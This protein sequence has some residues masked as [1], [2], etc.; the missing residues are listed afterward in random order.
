MTIPN[1]SSG[2]SL[3][4]NN[5]AIPDERASTFDSLSLVFFSFPLLF[6]KNLNG[7]TLCGSS[8]R[9]LD[10]VHPERRSR[11]NRPMKKE[12][13]LMGTSN[14]LGG[15]PSTGISLMRHI[16]NIIHTHT[17]THTHIDS[18]YT[19]TQLA[20]GRRAGPT[21]RRRLCGRG[22]CPEWTG[23]PS[24]S[25]TFELTTSPDQENE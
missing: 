13:R 22:K 24:V 15:R 11:R 7:S 10:P 14:W 23:P 16:Y 19:L 12:R 1:R 9:R 4:N 17:H 18:R 5:P 20:V 21:G 8:L 3:T 6:F 25:E 2:Q